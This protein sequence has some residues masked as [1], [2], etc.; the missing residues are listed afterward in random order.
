MFIQHI[1]TL[2][3]FIISYEYMNEHNLTKHMQHNDFWIK[4]N[5]T[6]MNSITQPHN[7]HKTTWTYEYIN[8][9]LNHKHYL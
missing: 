2:K 9:Q 1:K 4:Q 7:T 8:T 6:I 3:L 5:S